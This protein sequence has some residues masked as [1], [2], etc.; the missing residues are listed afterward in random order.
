[1]KLSLLIV[2]LNYFSLM[3]TG[4]DKAWISERFA[5]QIIK[6]K[7]VRSQDVFPIVGFE[8]QHGILY[9][10]TYGG[11]MQ[12][13]ITKKTKEGLLI[14]NFPYTINLYSWPEDQIDKYSKTKV[15]YQFIG[16]KIKVEI[17]IGNDKEIFL[18]TSNVYGSTFRNLLELKGWLLDL[19]LPSIK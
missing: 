6:N 17:R 18:Y 4:G 3:T 2:L 5:N 7:C 1:M 16:D 8:K 10:L 12:P 9:I 14:S 13:V 11:E 15:Y 19:L